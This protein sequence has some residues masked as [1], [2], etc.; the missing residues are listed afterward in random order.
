MHS[1]HCGSYCRQCLPGHLSRCEIC[2]NEMLE[3][4]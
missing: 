1:T 4:T 3:T 2:R